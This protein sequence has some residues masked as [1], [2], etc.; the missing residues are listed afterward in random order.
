ML[1]GASL[2]IVTPTGRS[3]STKW[4]NWGNNRWAFQPEIG[5]SER[6]GHWVEDACVAAFRTTSLSPG[7]KRNQRIPWRHLQ[8]TLN[9]DI[10]PRL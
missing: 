4:I 10:K 2:K 1:I 5:Y 8:G 7:H 6:W 3:D 9:Y